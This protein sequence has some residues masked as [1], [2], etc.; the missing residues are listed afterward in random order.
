M[1]NT[2]VNSEN[3]FGVVVVVVISYPSHRAH[4]HRHS[5]AFEISSR[6]CVH[7]NSTSSFNPPPPHKKATRDCGRSAKEAK[8]P[9]T[10][11][12]YKVIR[13]L[14]F[15]LRTRPLFLLLIL[16]ALETRPFQP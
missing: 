5:M 12:S 10:D 14:S 1:P 2:I 8:Y 9:K 11:Q 7:N 4:F 15:L 6:T 16:S 13:T 3:Q